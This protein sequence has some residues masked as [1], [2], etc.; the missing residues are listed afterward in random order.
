[1]QLQL[2]WRNLWRHPRRTAVILG[3]IIMGV[4]AMVFYSAFTRGMVDDMIRNNLANLTGH[5]QVQAPG[6]F[7]NPVMENLILDPDP[8]RGVLT[9]SLPAGAHWTSRLRLGGVVRS[10]R[11]ATGTVV[12]GIDPK[13]E[14][15][16]SFVA[17]A[18]SEGTFLDD[19]SQGLVV[20]KALLDH[21]EAKLGHRLVIDLQDASGRITSRAFVVVGVFRAQIEATEKQFIFCHRETLQGM[22]GVGPAVSE[23]CVNLPRAGDAGAV[24]AELAGQLPPDACVLLTWR[25]MLGFLS[26]YLD[27]MWIYA[28]VWNVVVFIAMAFGLVNTILMAVFER[29]REFGLVR[30][31]GVSPWGVIGRVLLETLL[32]LVV[33]I[34][35][36]AGVSAL[37]VGIFGR[38]GLN[39]SAF[40]AGSELFGISRIIYPAT[41]AQDY[42]SA[43]SIVLLLGLLVSLYPAVKAARITPVQA[44]T[45]R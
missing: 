5:L 16:L 43:M 41:T 3:A 22:V 29:V 24:A 1:M 37:T 15:N 20:G 6:F 10:A 7:E 42:L 19:T 21:L 45:Y 13:E 40:A 32:M 23:F 34:A 38:V 17:H 26:A 4:W 8:V 2:A 18:I 28:L 33:G 36:G 39:F 12:V 27:A 31:L 44:M 35:M 9:A 14:A 25:E 11:S 30:A